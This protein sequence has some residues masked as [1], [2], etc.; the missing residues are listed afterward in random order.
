MKLIAINGKR[1]QDPA[2]RRAT[3]D[4]I[5]GLW[6]ALGRPAI[7]MQN[8]YALALGPENLPPAI[9]SLGAAAP[10]LAV[11]IGGDGTFLRTARWIGSM[12]TPILGLNSG[13]LGFLSNVGIED[14]G[15]IIDDIA[16]GRLV[17]QERTLLRVTVGGVR[18][19]DT[20]RIL[21]FPYALNE[22]AI[23]RDD[24]ASMITVDTLLDGDQLATYRGDGLIIATP[25]GSTAYNLSVGGPI[26]SPNAHC[27]AL[28]PVAPHSLTMRPVV[29]PDS[30][31]LDIAVDARVPR[32]RLSLDG[33]SVSLPLDARLVVD[34]APFTTRILFSAD[35]TFAR[36]LRDKLLW[37]VR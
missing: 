4:F 26:L 33:R 34:R 20:S 9:V 7:A 36:N 6:E 1:R 21:D 3:L 18:V 16:E 35:H 13:N 25:T 19:D 10:E 15:R 22:V 17:V 28:S 14:A 5:A 23:V 8:R 2:R 12:P 24:N 31:Q 29:I 30:S 27:W 32:Y 11:S 37:G